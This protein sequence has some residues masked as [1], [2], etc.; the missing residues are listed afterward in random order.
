[1]QVEV[2]ETEV[3]A[4]ISIVVDYPEPLQRVADEVRFAVGQAIT[5]LVGMQVARIDVTVVDVFVPGDDDTD[6]TTVR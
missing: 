4:D 2:G 1:V 3:A 6:E 5:E